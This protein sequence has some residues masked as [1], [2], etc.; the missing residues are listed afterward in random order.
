MYVKSLWNAS[1]KAMNGH[2]QKD[3]PGNLTKVVSFEKNKE[4]IAGAAPG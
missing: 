3:I 2:Y 4:V 1:V